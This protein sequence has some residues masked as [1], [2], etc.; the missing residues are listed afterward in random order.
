MVRQVE[1]GT[2]VSFSEKHVYT[3]KENQGRKRIYK[4]ALGRCCKPGCPLGLV[5]HVHHIWPIKRGGTDDFTNYIVLCKYCHQHSR[6]HRLSED[7]KIE[8][9]VYKFYIELIEFGFCSDDM[10]NEE[11]EKRLRR[12]VADKKDKVRTLTK[13]AG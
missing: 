7:H 2:Y 5:L 10:D 3:N 4:K 9:L 1:A 11:F 8:L 6:L 13:V 12:I